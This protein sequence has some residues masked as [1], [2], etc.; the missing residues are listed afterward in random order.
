ML[1]LMEGNTSRKG[2][3]AERNSG[4]LIYIYSV[5]QG[6]ELIVQNGVVLIVQLKE[7]KTKVG[8]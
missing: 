2:T 7:L 6:E 3:D 5:N 8:W 4:R 1:L